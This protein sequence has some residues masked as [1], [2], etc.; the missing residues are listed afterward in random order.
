MKLLLAFIQKEDTAAL[1]KRLRD[2][3]IS[4]T[5]VESEGG[6]LRRRNTMVFIAVPDERQEA[7]VAVFRDVC[8]AR[9]ERVDFPI[10]PGDVEN[11]GLPTAAEI[12]VG[13]ATILLLDVGNVLK[14]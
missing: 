13:G 7:V 6:F 5:A 2:E 10:T 1:L 12:P 8:H 11:I 3:T 4:V 9:T 14:I